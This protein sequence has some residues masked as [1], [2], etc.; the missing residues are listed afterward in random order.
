MTFALFISLMAELILKF[1]SKTIFK[2]IFSTKYNK[3][4]FQYFDFFS[5]IH[6]FPLKV[7]RF[8]VVFFF[9]IKCYSV[10]IP[11]LNFMHFSSKLC[12]LRV[13]VV[14]YRTVPH[15][16]DNAFTML[17]GLP[18][19]L[20]INDTSQGQCHENHQPV[21]PQTCQRRGCNEAALPAP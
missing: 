12:G 4:D 2:Q 18:W 7:K 19:T 9:Q 1:C 15:L 10:P 8:E 3:T 20:H 11:T 14:Y 13:D 21:L 5:Y 6:I 16:S 17:F